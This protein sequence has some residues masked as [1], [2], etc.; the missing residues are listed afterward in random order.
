VESRRRPSLVLTEVKK[1]K[2]RR[3]ADTWKSMRE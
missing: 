2:S 3:E 1:M